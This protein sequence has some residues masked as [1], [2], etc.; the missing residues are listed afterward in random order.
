[1]PVIPIPGTTLP[2][3]TFLD[4]ANAALRKI[5]VKQ[6]AQ[7]LSGQQI[8]DCISEH[9]RMVGSFNCQPLMVFTETLLTLQF[10][11][12]KQIYTIGDVTGT[13]TDFAFARPMRISRANLFLPTGP[14]IRRIIYLYDK[15]QWERIQYQAIY[16]YPEHL[17]FD[18]GTYAPDAIDPAT[19]L[20]G[21]Y[22]KLY[23]HPIPDTDYQWEMYVWQSISKVVLPTDL[24]EY[25]DGWEDFMVCELA[26]RM[27]PE[28]GVQPSAV[29]VE[30]HRR[31]QAA[32]E[33]INQKTPLAKTDPA[34]TKQ[35]G[36]FYNWRSRDFNN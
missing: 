36:G 10:T 21:L 2:A 28:Y 16:T 19:G 34:L 30:Q 29:L 22:P 32:V 5:G 25:P 24:I 12:N 26:L 3:T 6:P 33:A 9:N 4:I 8:Q 20:T 18:H 31:A 14:V 17:Y 15:E 1:M 35:A 27:A 11:A 23:F 7:N 13:L